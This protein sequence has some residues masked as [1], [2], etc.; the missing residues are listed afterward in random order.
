M[1]APLLPPLLRALHTD[2][3]APVP[4]HRALTRVIAATAH[5]LPDIARAVGADPVAFTHD[6]RA[7]AL[8]LTAINAAHG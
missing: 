8:A 5:A 6:R 1:R 4:P 7:T 2:E 3:F